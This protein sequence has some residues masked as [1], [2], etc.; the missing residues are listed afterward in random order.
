MRCKEVGR[1]FAVEKEVFMKFIFFHLFGFLQ[2]MN[3]SDCWKQLLSGCI[4]KL[5]WYSSDA[6]STK[7]HSETRKPYLFKVQTFKYFK[8]VNISMNPLFFLVFNKMFL[9]VE[10]FYH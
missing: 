3:E 8:I 7:I 5:K 1:N 2:K 6:D 4:V 10:I 9:F